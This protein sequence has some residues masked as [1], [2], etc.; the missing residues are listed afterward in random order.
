MKIHKCKLK[1]KMSS[2]KYED[3][4]SYIILLGEVTSL[5]LDCYRVS[6]LISSIP[7]SWEA[8]YII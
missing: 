7:S 2:A 3:T 5:V 4:S 6:F 8:S 1:E